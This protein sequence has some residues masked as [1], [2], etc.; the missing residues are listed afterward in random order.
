MAIFEIKSFRGGISD[1]SDKGISGSFKMGKNLDIRKTDDTLS[2]GQALIDEGLFASQSPSASV[3][4]SSS[5]SRS[6]S[7]SPSSSASKTPSMSPSATPSSS[8]STTPSSSVSL[9]AS[10]S[11]SSSVSPSPSP[12]GGATSVFKDLILWF[13]EASDGYIYGFGDT[14]YIYR[15]DSSGFWMQVYKDSGGKI[16]GASE[17]PSSSR[18]KYLV[19]ATETTIKKKEI[20]GSSSWND[21]SVVDTN[22]D[23]TDW[24]TM[25]QINGALY[26]ANG[27]RLALFGY[28]D[29]YTNEALDLIP[30]NIAKTIVERNGTA[31]IGTY[32][33]SDPNKGINASIDVEVPLSQIGDDGEIFFANMTDSIAVKRFPGGGKV[34]P[35]GIAS[36]IKEINFFQWE[37]TALNWID[38]QSIGNIALFGVYNATSGYN[39][40]Y[41]YGRKNKNMPFVLNMDYEMDVDEIGAVIVNNGTVIAS[42]KDGSDYGVLATDQNNKAEGIY[43]GLE[44]K[45][46]LK[47]P[48]KIIPCTMAE[49][50]MKPLPHGSYVQFWYKVNK[51]GS[52]VQATSIDDLTNYNTTSSQKAVF[53]IGAEGE[54]FEPRI[55][56]HPYGNDTPEI[57][58]LRILFEDER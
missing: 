18:K 26:I 9:S 49:I 46:P 39:G 16:R 57:Y 35:G 6:I 55:V 42:Y 14:G 30:G 12:S 20:P 51:N 48:V 27:D 37:D 7:P 45:A 21:V 58:S 2:S 56:I 28:D 38:K 47:K 29:S 25:R 13:V 10:L 11:V 24:H 8:P 43:E 15:R 5:S 31:I 53:R 34:N 22:L 54:I 41:S 19:W 3:S 23:S 40:I 50:Q 17:K 44:L 4:P 36:S 33:A 32:R 1:Y 52:F